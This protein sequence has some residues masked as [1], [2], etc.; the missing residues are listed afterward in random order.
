MREEEANID[1]EENSEK[2][3]MA[4]VQDIAAES[5]IQDMTKTS[6]TLQVIDLEDFE[7]EIEDDINEAQFRNI[8]YIEESILTKA[9][10]TSKCIANQI[11]ASDVKRY[12]E[13][14]RTM[15]IQI[16]RIPTPQHEGGIKNKPLGR[17]RE[18]WSAVSSQVGRW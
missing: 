3:E 17:P 14:A 4:N 6:N 12:Q 8:V 16:W 7:S 5:H 11:R 9:L 13:D 15:E 18:A 1:T 10:K 2:Q